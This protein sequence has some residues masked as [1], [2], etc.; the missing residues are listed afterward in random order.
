MD[1]NTEWLILMDL[2]V[3]KTNFDLILENNS[4]D[5]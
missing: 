5:R 2:V 4:L 3:D 1:L